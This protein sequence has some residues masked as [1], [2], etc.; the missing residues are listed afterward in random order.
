MNLTAFA[1]KQNRVVLILLLMIIIL[2]LSGYNNLPRDSMPPFTVRIAQVVTQFPGASPERVENLI[3]DRIEKVIQEIPEVDYISS[4]SRTGLS[5]VT[6]SLKESTPAE[7]LQGIWDQIRRKIDGIQSELPSGIMGPEVKDEDVGVVYGIGIG[8]TNDGFE[9]Y[10]MEEYADNL[11][12]ILIKLDNAARV[13]IIGISDEQIFIEFD[14]AQLAKLKISSTKLK[15]IITAQNIINPAGEVNFEGERIIL[16][17]SG[18]FEVLDELKRL[19]IS[20]GDG[21]ETVYLGDI[22]K[23]TRGYTS[24]RKSIV[25]IDGEEAMAVFVNLKEGANIIS[26]GV[27]VDEVLE[28]FNATLPIGI[29]SRRIASQ[30]HE[31]EKNVNGFVSN[32]IQSIII[33][34]LVMF[35]FLGFRT[36]IVVASLIPSTVILTL[37]LMNT[38]GVGLNQVSLAALIMALGMLVDNAIVLAETIMVKMERGEAAKESAIAACKELMIPLLIST[39]TTSAAFLSFYLAQSVMGEIM[40]QLFTVITLALLSSWLMA[41]TIVP[42][43]AVAMIKIKKNSNK[44]PDMF[45]RMSVGYEKLLQFS[46]KHGIVF[47]VFIVVLF[48][49]SLW[50][51]SF[52]KFN[53][54]PDSERNLVTLDFNLP[55]GTNIETTAD[56]MQEIE[57]YIKDSLKTD[58]VRLKGVLDWSTFIGVGPSSYDLGYLPGEQNSGYAHM[59]INTSSGDDNQL[60]ID[61]LND[62]CFKNI[63]DAVVSIKRL[64]SGGGASV[65]VEVRLK[66][67]DPKELYKLAGLLK[68]RLNEIPGTR[69]VDDNWGP[70]I[71]KFYIKIDQ[72]QLQ[73]SGLT[74]QD[75]AMSLNTTLSGANVGEFREADNSLP[76]I[77][78]ATGSEQLSFK[79]VETMSIFS[80]ST[81]K[82][83]PLAQLAMVIP[84]WQYPTILRRDLTKTLTVQ[85]YLDEGVTANEVRAPLVAWLDSAKSEWASGYSYELGGEAESSGDAMGAVAEKLPLSFFIIL[86][87]LIIQFNSIR[88]TT[89]VLSTIPLG[90]IGVIGGL[91]MTGTEFS[92]TGFLG[93]ISLAGVVINNAI[94]LID[95]VQVEITELN[96]EVHEAVIAGAIERFRPILLTTFTTSLGMIPLW[97]GGGVMWRPMAVGMIFGLLFATVITLLFVPVM[98]QLFYKK[99]KTVKG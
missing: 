80:Q 66:G 74:N 20:V 2:G 30:D 99:P 22:T 27:K 7:K 86:L 47:I 19:I 32:V 75:I 71:K 96:K 23:I 94:V 33:V 24:P 78:R 17:A 84:Q 12:N 51:F 43:L 29:Q 4:Q 56:K 14:D 25:R 16:E 41:L 55:L 79:D 60:V 11:R 61:K 58:S 92:F 42:L 87:L 45:T 57:S 77:M 90:I 38:V 31:V 37:L 39:L 10:E 9:Y 3:T 82:N 69:N 48:F 68:K 83:V 13:E 62:Y 36:G 52:L 28:E 46:L 70:L 50:A 35:I 63:P 49:V 26:L 15:N 93:V 85:S 73:R 97:I 76:I 89:I 8:L 95:R 54:M 18:N 53:F 6:V 91:L 59:L 1:L 34:L 40:G 21:S 67:D 72:S 44:K 88:K 65:P 81:G 64:T 5:V 98:F